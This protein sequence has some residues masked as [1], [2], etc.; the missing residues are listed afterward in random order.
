MAEGASALPSVS[1]DDGSGQVTRSVDL[2]P[3]F[4]WM[5]LHITASGISMTATPL[6]A[7]AMGL[8]NAVIGLLG[9]VYFTGMFAG[10]FAGPLMIRPLGYRRAALV[11]MPLS[12]FGTLILL[13]DSVPLWALGRVLAGFSVGVAYVIA[14]SWIVA[15]AAP[16]IRMVSLS[17]YISGAL[18]GILTSQGLLAVLDPLKPAILLIAALIFCCAADLMTRVEVPI[19]HFPDGGQQRGR[20]LAMIREAAIPL[21]GVAV[22]GFVF[23]NFTTFYPSYGVTHGFSAETVS[24]IGVVTLGGAGAAQS[25]LGH[26]A[27][28]VGPLRLLLVLAVVA[29]A[30]GLFVAL[31]QPSGLTLLGV[32]V[33]WGA[34]ALTTYPLYGGVVYA[35]LAR[36][37]PFDVARIVLIAFGLPEIFGPIATGWL[38]DRSGPDMSFL[39]SAIFLVGLALCVVKGLMNDR[40]R[41]APPISHG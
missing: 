31:A 14:E 8:S 33:I 15:R 41:S 30:F 37:T 38:I 26:S 9:S 29:A 10:Y 35:A 3:V 6:L 23:A 17:I 34:A 12:L 5:T 2:W 21:T 7:G 28:R 1:A 18:G 39:V 19:A 25:F 22:T 24:I 16:S 32:S 11:I 40:S 4:V 27:E 13:T 36:E 20:T